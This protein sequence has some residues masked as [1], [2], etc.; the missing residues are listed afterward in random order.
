MPVTVLSVSFQQILTAVSSETKELGLR[1]AQTTV[2]KWKRRD[3]QL[4]NLM[5]KPT[6][7]TTVTSLPGSGK[8]GP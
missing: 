3:S 4:G 6:F 5:P 8:L 7:L 1:E 2:S